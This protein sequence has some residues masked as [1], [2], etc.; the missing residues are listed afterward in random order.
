MHY[1]LGGMNYF[2]GSMEARAYYI[3]FSVVE[4]DGS[5]KSFG[6]FAKSSF[7]IARTEVAR[8]SKRVLQEVKQF[9]DTNLDKL[10]ELYLKD[11]NR[12]ELLMF[13]QR[14]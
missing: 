8:Q 6:L 2:S 12:N 1:Q 9:V 3:G 11:D 14:R 4:I 13:I 5:F 10:F 7:K